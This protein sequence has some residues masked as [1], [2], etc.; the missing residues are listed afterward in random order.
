MKISNITTLPDNPAHERLLRMRRYSV[1]MAIR[2][3]C[4]LLMFVTHGVW[5]FIFAAGAIF[6]PYFAVVVANAVDNRNLQLDSPR[7]LP[8]APPQQASSMTHLG[9]VDSHGQ[10]YYYDYSGDD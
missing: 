4:F 1:M 8:A 5:V 3:V 7:E 2:F 9:S 10:R 6:L